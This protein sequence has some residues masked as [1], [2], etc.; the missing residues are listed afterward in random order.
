MK[1]KTW[2]W[3]IIQDNNKL[4]DKYLKDVE[5][6]VSMVESFIWVGGYEPGLLQVKLGVTAMH[7]DSF[8]EEAIKDAAANIWWKQLMAHFYMEPTHAL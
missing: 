2:V 3:Y 7:P 4:N 1:K 6:I 5:E 8:T